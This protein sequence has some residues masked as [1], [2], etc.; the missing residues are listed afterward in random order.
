M[1]PTQRHPYPKSTAELT[2]FEQIA[3]YTLRLHFNDDCSFHINFLSGL[4]GHS[5]APLREKELFATVRLDPRRR[6][7]LWANGTEMDSAT[8]RAWRG[9]FA[10]RRPE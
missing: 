2:G 6:A 1:L 3:D 4:I 7:L 5:L 9:R 10:S 8:L